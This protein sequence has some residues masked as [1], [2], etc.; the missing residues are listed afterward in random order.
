MVLQSVIGILIAPNETANL[1]MIDFLNKGTRDYTAYQ[2]KLVR[3]AGAKQ[4]GRRGLF[5]ECRGLGVAIVG[6]LCSA[7][8]NLSRNLKFFS[9]C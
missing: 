7:A 8:N 3:S 5:A 1:L 6:G 9:L 4:N 2:C